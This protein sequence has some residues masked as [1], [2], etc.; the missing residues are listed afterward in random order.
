MIALVDPRIERYAVEHSGRLDPLLDK[1][2]TETSATMERPHMLVGRLEGAL[3]RL[4]VRLARARRVLEIGTFTGYSAL[5][6]A[7]A[8]PAGGR[9]VT[10]EVD[11][12]H[13]AVARKY[14]RRSRHGRKIELKLGP[15]VETIRRLRGAFDLVFIDADKENYEKYWRSCVPRVRRGGLIVVDNV[16]WS[17]RVLRPADTLSRL[18]VRFNRM[19]AKDKRVEAVVLPVRDGITVAWKR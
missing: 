9:L 6:M 19:V 17:G 3:L 8:L 10:C 15:A 4:L 1:L 16:L 2:E 5:A 13:A 11:E 7:E 14:F 18:I 12:K